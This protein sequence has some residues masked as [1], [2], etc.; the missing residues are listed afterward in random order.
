[1]SFVEMVGQC[2]YDENYSRRV[3]RIDYEMRLALNTSDKQVDGVQKIE[4]K[5]HSP[6]TIFSM[7]FYMYLN[8]FKSLETTYLKDTGGKL[9][10][11]DIS[12]RKKN[13]WGYVD[14]KKISIL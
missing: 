7:Q 3:D 11:N 1:M 5:N 12:N 4:W 8:A 2:A 13:E 10:G 6:D 9:F 14:I